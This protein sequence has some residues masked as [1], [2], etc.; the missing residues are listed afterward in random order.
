[1][2]GILTAGNLSI[3]YKGRTIA[4]GLNLK[5]YSG[6]TALIGRNG[7]GKST[8][9]KTLTGNLRPL[10][11][12]VRI[13]GERL[14]SLSR[15][16]LSKLIAVVTT[17]PNIAGGLRLRELV[18][19]GRIPYTGKMGLLG[20]N[21]KAVVEKAMRRLDIW[22]I[23]ES[24]VAEVSDGERQKAM[25][26]KGLVQ[27][28]PIMLLDEPLSYLDVAARLEILDLIQSLAEQS[29]KAILYSTHEVAEALR[30]ASTVWMLAVDGFVEGTPLQLIG[31]GEIDRLFGKHNVKFDKTKGDFI[32]CKP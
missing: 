4:E 19:L 2:N 3:G 9:I 27:E 6:L 26:A 23:R 31:S 24:Y 1:M 13:K 29:G 21:D 32:L 28:T 8:L 11:G 22:R 20:A 5:L 15:K 12:E 10:E 18:E 7:S 25:I 17:D 30:V 14:S 16:E